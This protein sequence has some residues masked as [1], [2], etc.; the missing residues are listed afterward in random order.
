[1]P[2]IAVWATTE[3]FDTFILATSGA[4]TPYGSGD[5]FPIIQGGVT[6]YAAGNSVLTPSG[7]ETITNH[8]INGANNAITIRGNLDLINQVQPANGGTGL[9]SGTSGGVL[10]ATASTTYA[11]SSTL[12]ANAPLI[13]GG[14]GA[15]LGTGSFSGNTTKSVSA[16]GSSF[17]SGQGGS[18]DAN[19]N[20]AP[21]ANAPFTNAPQTWG[22][23]QTFGS[24]KGAIRTQANANDT[25]DVSTASTSDCGKKVLYTNTGIVTV[26]LPNNATVP[27]SIALEQGTTA[28]RVVPVCAT[29]GCGNGGGSTSPQNTHGFTGTFN[30]ATATI[31]LDVDTNVGGTSAHYVLTG[32]HSEA[33]LLCP[34]LCCNYSTIDPGT[35]GAVISLSG[36]RIFL[37][38][39]WWHS[40]SVL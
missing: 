3:N 6:K 29:T 7:S 24:T 14:A 38:S 35:A 26:T 36:W 22:P 33:Y 32:T 5:K 19:G 10:C 12:T 23:Q 16:A 9:S 39:L 2:M 17:P 30:A 34:I 28:G 4:S 8:T 25:L 20:W 11:F 27:C 1:M 40:S 31:Y 15:C 21:N 37:G 13:G 18:W